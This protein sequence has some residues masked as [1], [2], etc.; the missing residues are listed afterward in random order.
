MEP[1]TIPP[2]KIPGWVTFFFAIHGLFMIFGLWVVSVAVVALPSLPNWFVLLYIL[3]FVQIA[4][5]FF[6]MHLAVRLQ[7]SF[8]VVAVGWCI[9][10]ALVTVLTHPLNEFREILTILWFVFWIV[11]FLKSPR[12]RQSYQG[13]TAAAA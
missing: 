12:V 8:Q 11:Y 9:Y 4:W 13:S 6:T 7:P 10:A 2:N 1:S 3:G 5:Y